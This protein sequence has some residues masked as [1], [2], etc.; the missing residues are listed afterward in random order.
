[1][2]AS[3]NS[4]LA[5]NT[6][7]LYFRMILILGVNLYASRVILRMLGVEDVGIYNAV[8]SIVTMMGFVS[9]ALSASTSRFITFELGRGDS[10]RVRRTFRVSATIYYLLAIAVVII[11][12]TAGLWLAS[13]QLTLPA[14]R[15][16]AAL[17][18]YQFSIVSFVLSFLAIPFNSLIIA[19]E[20]MNAFAYISIFEA[21]A[22]LGVLYLLPL[23]ALDRLVSY[24]LML[25]AI[26]ALLLAMYAFYCYRHFCE[27]SCRWLWDKRLSRELGAYAGWSVM[28]YAAVVGSNQGLNLLLNHFFNPV[29]NA[30]R[31]FALQIQSAVTQF[32]YNFQL[33]VRPQVIKCYAQG[34]L[35]AMH[36]LMLKS[37]RFSYLMAIIVIAPVLAYTRQLLDLWLVAPPEH[38]VV[39]TRLTLIVCLIGSLSQHTLMAIHAT[40]EIRRFQILEGLSLI[41]ILPI[42]Y[43][44][45]TFWHCAPE[46]IM[47]LYV[48]VEAV[49]QI[50]RVVIVYPKVHLPILRLVT[51]ILPR[52][53]LVSAI[54]AAAVWCFAVYA[55]PH[56]VGMLLVYVAVL[57]VVSL[58]ASGFFGIDSGERRALQSFVASRLQHKKGGKA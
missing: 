51:H 46:V 7:F 58:L 44:A 55:V 3:N 9:N 17:L 16:E 34:E 33:A 28:G 24:S 30:A 52:C 43:V 15:M 10:E 20:R 56:S 42:A 26:Q 2:S 8:G 19:H 40:G 53:M 50:V 23:L 27:T 38:L 47:A 48:V 13:T 22:K 12:E 14:E 4:R 6:L 54:I 57:L 31:M 1:M 49:T 25:S 21:L 29:V 18:C 35:P 39:F 32:Y 11:A 45:C 37:A 41:S 36:E 5:K